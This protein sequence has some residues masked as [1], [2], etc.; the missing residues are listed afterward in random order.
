MLRRMDQVI[1]GRTG[2][3]VSVAGLGCGGHSRLG[4]SQGASF[5]E[6]VRLVR[7]ALDLGITYIDT[8]QRYGTEHIVG[9]AIRGRRD[10]V[11]LS[12]KVPAVGDDGSRLDAAG[13]ARAVEESQRRLGVDTID[14]F[15]LHAVLEPQYDYCVAELV[16]EMERLREK[17][18]IRFLGI[19]EYFVGDV[20]HA[21]LQKAV[22]SD[23]WDVMMLGFNL[24]NPSARHLVLRD[25]IARNTGVEV[26]HAV[27][28]LLSHPDALREAIAGEIAAGHIDPGILDA[29]DPLG[30]LVHADGAGSVVEAAYRFAR[31]EPGCH[32]ILTGT[33]NVEHLRSNV[34][35]IN[36]GPLPEADL[37][38]LD[39]LFGHLSSLSAN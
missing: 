1:L 25:A 9:E 20:T 39:A 24:L 38:R 21:M 26:M 28:R 15:H 11:V 10:S 22:R 2:V 23:C 16:P 8:A 31:H 27:R 13:L 17:G 36:L 7:E 37:A 4:Q 35:A 33:G 32:V 34:R 6:S 29:D 18:E 5:E 12:T 3:P 19:T 30:F 14:V